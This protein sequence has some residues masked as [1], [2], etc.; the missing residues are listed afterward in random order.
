MSMPTLI[1]TKS[2]PAARWRSSAPS[3][4]RDAKACRR[5]CPRPGRPV[6]RRRARGRDR[7]SDGSSPI[8]R[9]SAQPQRSQAVAPSAAMTNNHR[10]GGS[11][12]VTDVDDPRDALRRRAAGGR[13]RRR[14]A[15]E[16]LAGHGLDARIRQLD[17]EAAT[18][19]YPTSTATPARPMATATSAG[20]RP[21]AM[22]EKA[23]VRPRHAQGAG[24][25][26][27]QALRRRIDELVVIDIAS[28]SIAA[29]T[30][31]RA[32]ASSTT[33]A[34]TRMAACS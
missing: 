6:Q 25:Q 7:P 9:F 31:P 16:G 15:R 18:S 3:R 24:A 14:G 21:R 34:C 17:A 28:A 19:T 33:S 20:C 10:V 5:G 23:W 2:T 8:S 29:A 27:W 22:V 26:R 1:D 12:D 13:R 4:H 11:D 32:R 30:R